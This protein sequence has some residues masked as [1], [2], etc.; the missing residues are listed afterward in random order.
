MK[1]KKI[2]Y[3]AIFVA[4]GIVLPQ[5][6]HLVGGPVIGSILLPMHI[7]VLV[8]AMLL[9]PVSGLIIGVISVLVGAALGMPAM[10]MAFFMLFELSAYGIIAGFLYYRK[11]LN[12][13][14]SLII[15]MIFGRGVSML[16][17]LGAI[18]ILSISLPPVFGTI[19]IYSAGLP[20]I[21]LQLILVPILVKVLEK[22][23]N[24][25]S[26]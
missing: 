1:T 21:G 24:G 2:T 14:L 10:P 26:I 15:S 4:L 22:I 3:L 5:F 23:K 16:L 17:M 19:G 9:G 7:P 13:Y 18:N 12:I 8:G 11:K 25:N 6:F 20:G